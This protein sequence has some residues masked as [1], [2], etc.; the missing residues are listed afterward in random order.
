MQL[1]NERV[2]L[3]VRY[4]ADVIEIAATIDAKLRCT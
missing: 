1:G 2:D 3:G 4:Q